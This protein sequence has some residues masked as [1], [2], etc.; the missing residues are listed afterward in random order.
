MYVS[1]E[2]FFLPMPNEKRQLEGDC[3]Y[4]LSRLLG[5]LSRRNEKVRDL[6]GVND[7]YARTR[8]SI[9]RILRQY[10][11]DRAIYLEPRAWPFFPWFRHPWP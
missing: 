3:T 11:I 4:E 6:F 2:M 5:S 7:I 8:I 1:V 10:T 9:P